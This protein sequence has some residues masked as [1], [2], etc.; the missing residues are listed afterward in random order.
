[1][2]SKT[3]DCVSTGTFNS[4]SRGLRMDRFGSVNFDNMHAETPTE[5]WS[6]EGSTQFHDKSMP[7]GSD[8]GE[9]L[10]PKCMHNVS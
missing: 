2:P 9:K 1:M 8:Q 10:N 5:T 7:I 3:K 4:G 6:M